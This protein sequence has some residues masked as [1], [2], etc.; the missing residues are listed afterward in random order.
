MALSFGISFAISKV[1]EVIDKLIVTE[2][3]RQEELQEMASKAEEAKSNIESLTSSMRDNAKTV[4]D[5][6][7]R[8]AE[9]SQGVDNL[10]NKNI[11][12]STSEYEEFLDLTNQLSLNDTPFLEGCSTVNGK[13]VLHGCFVAGRG[14]YVCRLSAGNR[15]CTTY[16]VSVASC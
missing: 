2:K 8:Y 4:N 10:S 6:K 12:L 16:R 7:D 5:V 13:T 11:S 15:G 14:C 9:L 1:V 3:E